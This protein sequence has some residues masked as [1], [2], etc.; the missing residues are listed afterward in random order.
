MEKKKSALDPLRY[1]P[2][3]GGIQKSTCFLHVTVATAMMYLRSTLRLR[4]YK[5][6]MESKLEIWTPPPKKKGVKKNTPQ[7]TNM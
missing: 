5:T 1:T 6:M 7:K 2:F 3:C 4:E